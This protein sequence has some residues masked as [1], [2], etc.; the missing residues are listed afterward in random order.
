[1]LRLWH[2]IVGEYNL[3][4]IRKMDPFVYELDEMDDLDDPFADDEGDEA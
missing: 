2:W 4:K 3:W 1:M